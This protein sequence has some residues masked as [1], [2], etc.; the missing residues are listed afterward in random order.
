METVGEFLGLSQDLTLY[1]YFRRHYCHFFPAMAQVCRATFV[2]QAAN[3]W[4]V[5]ERLWQAMLDSIRHDPAL[6]I[7]DSF[8]LPVCR[9]ARAT[10]ADASGE[11]PHSG[12]MT[13]PGRPS[14][15]SGCIYA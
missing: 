1:R 12:G 8:P 14:M 5:K 2:R 10:A 4:K 3:P 9:F 11:K 15:V 6:A 13:W 7:V